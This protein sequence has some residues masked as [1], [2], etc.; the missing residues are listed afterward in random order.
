MIYDDIGVESLAAVVVCSLVEKLV[1]WGEKRCSP[2]QEI[3][4][5]LTSLCMRP[6]GVKGCSARSNVSVSS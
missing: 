1:D 3:P 2:W 5:A 6:W 4:E